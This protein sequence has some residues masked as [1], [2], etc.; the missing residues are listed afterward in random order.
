VLRS[1]LTACLTLLAQ[2]CTALVSAGEE[3]CAS[4][5]D[6]TSRG[7]A[8]AACVEQ[9]CVEREGV[10]DD[11]IWGC[12]GNVVEPE[13]DPTQLIEFPIRLAYAVG[14][15]PLGPETVID[16]CDKLD[17]TC[18]GTDPKYPKGLAPGP[19]GVVDVV[20]PEGFDGFV[21]IQNPDIVDSRVYVGR[22]IVE[23][24]SVKEVRLLSPSDYSV[25]STL[26]G[27][28][29]DPE[30][31]TA[32]VLAVDCQQVAV[33]GV[34]FESPNAD[35]DSVEF[36][37]INQSPTI[38]PTATATDP[39]GFG[40][41]FNMPPSSAVVRSFRDADDAFVGESSFQILPNTLSYVQVAPTPQ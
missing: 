25:L 23:P 10:V 34:R 29:L 16:V 6:C 12:L 35:A 27:K 41:F 40:G 33:G 21:R 11:P 24:P 17:I 5:G 38:P 3:Q 22:P 15:A 13:A 18:A 8:N 36:Y 32:I 1:V 20:V 14:D 39:D 2:G 4:D 31:G 19:D 26:A 9:V 7:F 28:S 30:R 37:L